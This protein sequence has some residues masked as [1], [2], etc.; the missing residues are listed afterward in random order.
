MFIIVLIYL[1]FLNAFQ[2]RNFIKQNLININTFF[3]TFFLM[4]LN[5]EITYYIL[6]LPGPI[7]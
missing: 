4:Y 2:I 7:Y 5:L 3:T 1:N 6:R